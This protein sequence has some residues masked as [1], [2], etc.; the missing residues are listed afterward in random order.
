M[1]TKIDFSF[2][3]TSG[4]R[5]AATIALL[6][7]SRTSRGV[8]GRRHQREER[9]RVEAG[10][11]AFVDR[12]YVG[13]QRNPLGRRGRDDPDP[14]GAMQRQDGAEVAEHRVDVAA[15]EI[16]H[17]RRRALVRHVRDLDAGAALE[18]LERKMAGR[19]VALRGVAEL[20]GWPWRGR[21]VRGRS[22]PASPSSPPGCSGRPP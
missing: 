14:V 19:A 16:V 5:I 20:A 10:Q 22:W 6:S 2:S 17:R 3:C 8:S 7:F 12:R 9:R 11:G 21:S 4:V 1:S 18:Q 13:Q 15:G